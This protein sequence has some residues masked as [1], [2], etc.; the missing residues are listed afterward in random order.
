MTVITMMRCFLRPWVSSTHTSTR[1]GFGRRFLVWVRVHAHEENNVDRHVTTDSVRTDFEVRPIQRM[2]VEHERNLSLS[3]SFSWF[4]HYIIRSF[5]H[6]IV[7]ANMSLMSEISGPYCNRLCVMRF[8]R[9]RFD[10]CA[11]TDDSR[12]SAPQEVANTFLLNESLSWGT[13]YTSLGTSSIF[14][15]LR[16]FPCKQLTRNDWIIF[17]ICLSFFILILYTFLFHRLRLYLWTN[18]LSINWNKR[19]EQFNFPPQRLLQFNVER[20][21]KLD[22][23]RKSF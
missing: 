21:K 18:I 14:L 23:R 1:N 4:R 19:E 20:V 2:L 8:S 11:S 12:F 6:N 7:V 17:L 15:N 22:E 16:I 13:N 3:H 10:E 9:F 5:T